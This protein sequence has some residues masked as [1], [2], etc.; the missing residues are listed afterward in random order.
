MTNDKRTPHVT[1]QEGLYEPVKILHWGVE[2]TELN[3]GI[4]HYTVVYVLKEDGTVEP[5]SPFEIKYI[6]TTVRIAPF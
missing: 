1:S 2:Y 3:N 4:G 6:D 5:V